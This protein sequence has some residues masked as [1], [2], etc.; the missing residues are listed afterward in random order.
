MAEL[1]LVVSLEAIYLSTFVLIG[2]NRLSA[3][4]QAVRRPAG[5]GRPRLRRA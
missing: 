4:Q 5:Q 3:V 2:Q 1:T